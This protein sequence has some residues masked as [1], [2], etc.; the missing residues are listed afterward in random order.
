[1]LKKCYKN[2]TFKLAIFN[3]KIA[4]IAASFLN[5]YNIQILS[6]FE[7]HSP[8]IAMMIN[9]FGIILFFLTIQKISSN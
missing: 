9:N 8:Y 4:K 1:M 5:H 3:V 6:S 2:F 7:K